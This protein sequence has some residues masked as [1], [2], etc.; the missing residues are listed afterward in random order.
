M[1][2]VGRVLVV[3]NRWVIGA[4]L[5]DELDFL[6]GDFSAVGALRVPE[7]VACDGEALALLG[8]EVTSDQLIRGAAKVVDAVRPVLPHIDLVVGVGDAVDDAGH[9]RDGRAVLAVRPNV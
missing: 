1:L 2:P 6:P 8:R 7:D 9:V 4:Q 5:E 3:P